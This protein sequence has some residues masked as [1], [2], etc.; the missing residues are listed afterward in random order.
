MD[1]DA[2]A[3]QGEEAA[4]DEDIEEDDEEGDADF[5]VKCQ[6]C[7]AKEDDEKEGTLWVQC[8]GC[9]VWMHGRCVGR[10]S[11]Q[12]CEELDL[13]CFECQMT[14]ARGGRVQR[15][16]RPSTRRPCTPWC[17]PPGCAGGK[18]CDKG[19]GEYLT[20]EQ[21]ELI[22]D[23][24]FQ[25]A[26][27]ENRFNSWEISP[28]PYEKCVYDHP[29]HG[30]VECTAVSWQLGK[31][32]ATVQYHDG[33]Y[34]KERP[35]AFLQRIVRFAPRWVDSDLDAEAARIG[36]TQFHPPRKQL[37]Y[38]MRRARQRYGY[39]LPMTPA[40]RYIRAIKRS[41]AARAEA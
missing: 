3:S 30:L 39:K 15:Q 25:T 23:L 27:M 16:T 14:V 8:A 35:G 12:Q 9:L 37:K 38:E 7:G 18:G 34:M 21:R 33:Q 1:V 41:S 10:L 24:V 4:A 29:E 2:A 17:S 6:G 5:V 28:L 20:R 22:E 11:L 32:T 13:T 40:G 19:M 31:G 36:C 26:E